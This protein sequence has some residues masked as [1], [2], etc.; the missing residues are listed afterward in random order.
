MFNQAGLA[1]LNLIL[2]E[3]KGEQHRKT[4]IIYGERI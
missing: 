1:N 4:L 3:K 2:M